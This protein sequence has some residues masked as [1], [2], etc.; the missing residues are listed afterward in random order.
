MIVPTRG[1]AR[2]ADRSRRATIA[3][4]T[5]KNAGRKQLFEEVVTEAHEIARVEAAAQTVLE[6]DVFPR[7]C[8]YSVEEIMERPIERPPVERASH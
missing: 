2:P 1:V 7:E 4:S 3:I 5:R 6:E 8:P